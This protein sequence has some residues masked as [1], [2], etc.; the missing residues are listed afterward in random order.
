V[1]HDPLELGLA[2]RP[3]QSAILLQVRRQVGLG[4]EAT[5]ATQCPHGRLEL[6]RRQLVVRVFVK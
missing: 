6:G 1:L 4:G 2:D 3:I 5:I